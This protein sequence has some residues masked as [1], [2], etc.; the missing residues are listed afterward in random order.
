[1]YTEKSFTLLIIV[2][3]MNNVIFIVDDLINV[4]MAFQMYKLSIHYYPLLLI[5]A[6]V[7]T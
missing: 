1:M 6:V 4:T 5:L 7:R 2:S 3:V